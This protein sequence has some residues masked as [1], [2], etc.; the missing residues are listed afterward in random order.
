ML[1]SKSSR[2]KN[3]SLFPIPYSLLPVACCL[4]PTPYSLLP[5]ACCLLPTPYSLLPV[6]Y[7]KCPVLSWY[8]ATRYG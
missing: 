2:I 1:L 6:A 5:V 7:S 3:C 8:S 4:L